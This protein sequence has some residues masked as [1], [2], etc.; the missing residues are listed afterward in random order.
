MIEIVT[1]KDKK[2]VY[3]K[4]GGITVDE[5]KVVGMS[6]SVTVNDPRTTLGEYESN[7]RALEVRNDMS[8]K[9]DGKNITAKYTMPEK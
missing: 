7:E 6:D 5:N 1:Q 4:P 9:I 2:T 3:V 8:V